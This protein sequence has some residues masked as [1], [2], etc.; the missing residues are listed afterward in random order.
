MA[1]LRRIAQHIR[2]QPGLQGAEWLWSALRGPYHKFLD[3]HG[4]GVSIAVGSVAHVRMPTEFVGGS[5]EQ[6]EPA[7]IAA[8]L[9]WL[10]QHPQGIVL[11]VGCSI[12]IYSLIALFAADHVSVV[13]FDSDLAS[14]RAARRMTKYASGD[15]LQLVLGFIAADPTECDLLAG[16]I[17]TTSKL[18]EGTA[19][20]A[21]AVRFVCI[22]DPAAM[23]LPRRR[24]DDLFPSGFDGRACLIKCDVE[25]AEQIV[26]SGATG[27]LSYHR[28]DLLLSVHPAE[29]VD[30]GHSIE[31][32]RGFLA[33]FDYTASTIAVD[34][35]EHWWCCPTGPTDVFRRAAATEQP[36]L[37][38]AET[39]PQRQMR[40]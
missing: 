29:L 4:A 6:F 35:E 38:A 5:W 9:H 11:D 27:L 10:R 34:H 37:Q 39:V 19:P 7:S 14:L 33:Q 3:L 24:L 13:A 15:R 30:Y 22:G 8:Y 28:P 25:G 1:L 23:D 40:P 32:L 2:H 20:G 16:A 31:S 17:A 36:S 12:G 26:L 21:E 18:I